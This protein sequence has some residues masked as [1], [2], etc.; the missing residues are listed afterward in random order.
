MV[1]HAESAALQASS[2]KNF[3]KSV[4]H[5]RLLHHI[6]LALLVSFYVGS[7][8]ADAIVPVAA[9]SI[10]RCQRALKPCQIAKE[11]AENIGDDLR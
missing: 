1:V 9:S 11:G 7:K 2:S 5:E 6:V 10:I 4:M 8:P 3:S